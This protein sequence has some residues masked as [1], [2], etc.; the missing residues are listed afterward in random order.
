MANKIDANAATTSFAEESTTLGTLPGSPIWY[1]RE[2]NT[3]GDFGGEP[4]SVARKPLG[5]RKVSKGSLTGI[6][7][8]VS[9]NEDLTQSNMPRLLQTFT[10]SAVRQKPSTQTYAGVTV[11]LTSVASADNSYNA[12]S[13]LTVFL[14]K[15]LL[16]A[17][18]F[19]VAANNGL[20]TAV[21][22]AAGKVTVAETLVNETPSAAAKLEAVGVQFAASDCAMTYSAPTLTLTTSVFNLTTLGLNVG[23]WVHI[24]G[25][26]AASKFA[27]ATLFGYAR[28]A[29]IAAN[30]IVFDKVRGLVP[31]ADTGTGKTIHLYF[32][33]V[34]KD[35]T[36]DTQKS[37]QWE[38]QLGSDGVGIQ[39]QI[40]T[41][42]I[43]NELTL[44][45]QKKDKL[46]V[47]LGFIGIDHQLRT[48]TQGIL[49]GT[50]VAAFNES[51]INNSSDLFL[52][53]LTLVDATTLSP[54]QYYGFSS[55][56][57]LMIANNATLD[58]AEGE[59]GG[60]DVTLG[61]FDVTGKITAY[62]TTVAAISAM[63]ANVSATYD[64]IYAA[65]NAGFVFDL[66][67][68]T[69]GGAIPKIEKNKAIELPIDTQGCVGPNG[70]TLLFG[71]WPYLPTIAMPT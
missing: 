42:C 47:D 17:S 49:A 52:G 41:G 50:R 11:A 58:E 40:V 67:L 53:R 54:A 4:S 39:S 43:G 71:F 12:A 64:K 65:Q 32:Q 19:T 1:A 23:E 22:T 6:A 33:N 37:V 69:L 26:S 45:M 20:K 38:V 68:V 15:H 70:Y 18:G 48:G 66:P 55:E 25:D 30:A 8:K 10:Q 3:I 13:G 2:P 46:N 9:L 56:S 44:N 34:I 16:K 31:A 63:R 14:A 51:A 7:P 35:E 57:S 29:S 5:T 61:D 28:I 36:V 27:T 24:G 60:F 62:F 59:A 21:T